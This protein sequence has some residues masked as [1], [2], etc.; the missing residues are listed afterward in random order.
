MESK[1]LGV[2]LRAP[3]YKKDRPSLRPTTYQIR[4]IMALTYFISVQVQEMGILLMKK[5]I[6]KG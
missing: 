5:Q 2:N 3:I 1:G 6:Q 4:L